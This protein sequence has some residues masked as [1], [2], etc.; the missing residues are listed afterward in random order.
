M[1][2]T[3]WGT[4][5]ALR[6]EQP[7]GLRLRAAGATCAVTSSVA[8]SLGSEDTAGA[9]GTGEQQALGPWPL[10]GPSRPCACW[11]PGPTLWSGH[12]LDQMTG[13]NTSPGVRHLVQSLES[14]RGHWGHPGCQAGL[15]CHHPGGPLLATE[16]RNSP[17]A[18]AVLLGTFL[19]PSFQAHRLDGISK[20]GVSGRSLRHY[21][22][23]LLRFWLFRQRSKSLPNPGTA[24][25]R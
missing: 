15:C 7:Q 6:A 16:N 8:L 21:P 14:P 10:L 18:A 11:C 25:E 23:P 17:S 19:V 1:H 4:L 24:R 22:G 2:W 13:W 5:T 9:A 12:L 20:P 3:P